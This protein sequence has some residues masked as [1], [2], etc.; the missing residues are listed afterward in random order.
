MMKEWRPSDSRGFVMLGVLALISAAAALAAFQAS[1]DVRWLVGA[2]IIIC[3]WPYVYFV[4]TPLNNRLI[5]NAAAP[6]PDAREL[7]EDWG[8][9]EWGLS[10]IGVVAAAVFGWA[11]S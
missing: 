1:A 10:L 4:V 8:F 6:E 2:I 3:S 9:L 5:A 7:V 11:L